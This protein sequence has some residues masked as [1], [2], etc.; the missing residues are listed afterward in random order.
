MTEKTK[1]LPAKTDFYAAGAGKVFV[2]NLIS[3][4]IY[5]MYWFYKN[6]SAIARRGEKINAFV[7]GWI[8]PVFFVF[9]LFGFIKNEVKPSNPTKIFCKI[10]PIACCIGMLL[11]F[12]VTAEYFGLWLFAQFFALAIMSFSLAVVQNAINKHNPQNKGKII[13]WQEFL[14]VMFIPVL[15]SSVAFLGYVSGKK[16]AVAIAEEYMTKITFKHL[17]VYPQICGRNGYVL[18]QYP[19]EFINYFTTELMHFN[20][21]LAK[22]GSNESEA[23]QQQ[24]TE[25]V[26]ILADSAMRDFGYLQQELSRRGEKAQIADACKMLDS[27]ASAIIFQTIGP[28]IK[29]YAGRL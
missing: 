10:A 24:S 14:V 22:R 11:P 13:T 17:Y 15:F 7:R 20:G 18:R 12:A 21:Y 1:N 16:A 2:L 26:N 3:F 8:L 19:Q 6:W 5:S 29:F 23:W 9:P 4:G 28:E 27:P 25:T